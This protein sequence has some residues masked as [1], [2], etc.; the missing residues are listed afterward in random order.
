VRPERAWISVRT[1]RGNADDALLRRMYGRRWRRVLDVPPGRRRRHAAVVAAGLVAVFGAAM[2]ALGRRRGP[3]KAVALAGAA[4]WVTGTTEFA[5]ARIAPGPR[6]PRELAAM[7]LTSAV[8]PPV[9]VGH[10]VRGWLRWRG[11]RPLGGPR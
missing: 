5:A 4:A 3:W 7:A 10:W 8:I 9:A 11:A 6:T 1:Q 2:T